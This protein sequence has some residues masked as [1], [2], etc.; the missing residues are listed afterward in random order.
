MDQRT[1]PLKQDIVSI[2]DTMTEKIGQLENQL[3]SAVEEP[4]EAVKRAV[5][6]PSYVEEHPWA[7]VG[8]AVA[9]GYAVGSLTGSSEPEQYVSIPQRD[10]TDLNLTEWHQTISGNNSSSS[11]PNTNFLDDLKEQ[12]RDE[13]AE[14]K[15]TAI[16]S[17]VE[18]LR[19]VIRDNLPSLASELDRAR[20][21]Q[22]K[23]S[24]SVS[25]AS[26]QL[27]SGLSSR[28]VGK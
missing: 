8:T 4:G 13:I 15:I 18:L 23:K 12:F 22:S 10:T 2:R 1:D 24:G 11:Q 20:Q 7:M 5:D 21:A 3:R 26:A 14:I 19:S 17:A 27:N 6:L 25:L 16:N 28:S 9:I